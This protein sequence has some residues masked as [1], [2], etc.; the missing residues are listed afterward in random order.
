MM[1]FKRKEI[2]VVGLALLIALAGYL[3][4]SYKRS[5]A[6]DEISL[7]GGFGEVK[8]VNGDY[9]EDGFF[10]EA[11]L[12][13][14]LSRSEAKETLNELINNDKTDQDAKEKAQQQVLDM[15]KT[16]DLE[17]TAEGLIKAKGFKDAVIYITDNKVNAMVK[18]DGLTELEAAKIQEIITEITGID[19]TNIKI[20]EVN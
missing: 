5:Q 15:A 13:R 20:V 3:N 9:K 12:D 10:T 14:E 8:L 2:T 1:V 17:A 19:A 6:V 16:T 4:V 18:A 11:R 7:D